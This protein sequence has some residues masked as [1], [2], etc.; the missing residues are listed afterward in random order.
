LQRRPEIKDP[1]YQ[2]QEAGIFSEISFK[3]KEDIW[4]RGGEVVAQYLGG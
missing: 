1:N 3:R 2:A 4:L